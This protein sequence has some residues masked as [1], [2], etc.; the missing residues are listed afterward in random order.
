[1]KPFTQHTGLVCPLDRVNVDTDQI[2]PKQFLKSI[3][4]TGFGPN[5]FDEW[6]Y[7]DAGQPGQ[8]NRKRPINSDFVLNFPRYRGASVLLARDN[9]GCGSSREHA[10]WAL[11]EYGFRTVIAPSFADIFFNNSFKNGLLP[12][13]LNK[14]E[15]DALFA[16][17]QV[18]EG[19]TLTVDLAAQQVIT[20]DGTT[21]AFQID[22]FRK[23]CL[24]NG[25]DDIGLT[26]QHAEA[27]RAFE[28]THR[29]RQ[30][31]L[32]APLR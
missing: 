4:R 14:V 22:T 7:L 19:Y 9:F 6:R 16:Q 8:D 28:A 15:V 20:P 31:W 10:A 27:I 30:P 11:D 25:L 26:L 24:L 23:H 18:T 2:I 13:V 12:L 5:L 29:I 3:K 17:C 21:Y 1:M 32:F